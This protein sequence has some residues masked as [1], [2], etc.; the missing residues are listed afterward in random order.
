MTTESDASEVWAIAMGSSLDSVPVAL[1]L[2]NLNPLPSA[3][4]REL[5]MQAGFP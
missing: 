4:E 3:S 1:H 5:R 2:W